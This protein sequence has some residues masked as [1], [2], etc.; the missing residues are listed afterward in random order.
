[1]QW[2]T[3]ESKRMIWIAKLFLTIRIWK[4]PEFC[5]VHVVLHIVQQS[6]RLQVPVD[7][8]LAVYHTKKGI[9][10]GRQFFVMADQTTMFL[11]AVVHKVFHLKATDASILR[12]SNNSIWV[13]AA[14]ILHRLDFSDMYIQIWLRWMSTVFLDYL[15]NTMY[16]AAT[17]TKGWR[18]SLRLHYW[19]LRP[20]SKV[21]WPYMGYKLV[22][23]WNQIWNPEKILI[24]I[25]Y[26]NVCQVL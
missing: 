18:D 17:H 7:A 25:V 21:G 11:Q 19:G 5:P 12:W 13:T 1:M 16:T 20:P 3:A 2:Y 4:N 26:L 23:V 9:Y 6:I 22:R 10:K 14:D 8:P 15:Q 24:S